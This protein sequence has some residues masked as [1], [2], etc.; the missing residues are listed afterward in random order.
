MAPIMIRRD[1]MQFYKF[2]LR[3]RIKFMGKYPSLT[4][5]EVKE[6]PTTPTNLKNR[7]E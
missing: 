1:H 7:P 4:W 5:Q 2:L 6:Q 3:K